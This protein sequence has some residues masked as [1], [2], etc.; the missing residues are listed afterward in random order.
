M[1]TE[2]KQAARKAE[3]SSLFRILARAG[4]F[5]AGIVHGLVGVIVLIL[6]FGGKGEGDQAGAY[7]AIVAVPVGFVALWVLAIAL[8]AL[9]AWHAA[10]GL[11]ADGPP[12]DAT[13][14]A[15]KWWRRV[16]EWGQALVFAALGLIAASV[17]LGARP[18]ADTAAEDASRGILSIPGGPFVL[19]AIGLGVGIGGVV[20]IVMGVGRSFEQQL[21]LPEGGLGATVKTLGIGGFIAKGIAL[22]VVGVLLLIA[23]VRI[24]PK[25]AG[26]LDGAIDALL[27]LPIG[28]WLAGLVGVGFLAYAVFCGFRAWYARI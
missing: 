2:A 15:T 25:A 9:A 12:D 10:E 16:A 1:R 27:R 23:A 11:L 14:V 20:F 7:K 24:E 28:P 5:A 19:G 21:D 13:S 17:A 6:A 22:V 3:S 26:G 8:V 18:N 4:Y